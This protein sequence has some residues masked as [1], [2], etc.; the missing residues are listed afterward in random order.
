MPSICNWSDY[1]AILAINGIDSGIWRLLVLAGA[2]SASFPIGASA[3]AGCKC[4]SAGQSY[5]L[6]AVICMRGQLAR[7]EMF[8][9][10]TSW[11]IIAESCPETRAPSPPGTQPQTRVAACWKAPSSR[12]G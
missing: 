10:N 12:G 9:N 7:C 3:G 2:L 11:K 1:Q 8:L 4:R 6:G 5:D